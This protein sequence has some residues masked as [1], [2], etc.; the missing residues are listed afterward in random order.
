MHGKRNKGG[1]T[2]LELIIVV[3]VIGILA[4]IALPRY[5]KVAE[6][7]RAGEAKALLGAMRS[8]QMRYAAQWG[9]Y[10]ENGAALDIAFTTT[11]YFVRQIPPGTATQVVSG[12][13]ADAVVL[14]NCIRSGQENPNYGSYWIAI[15]ADGTLVADAGTGSGLI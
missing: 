7:G 4:S 9:N 5:L 3:I 1:F 11:K 12:A 15:Q 6:K 13:G 2:L 14:A 8:A 10:T